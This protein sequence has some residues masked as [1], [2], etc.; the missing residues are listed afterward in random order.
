MFQA[1]FKKAQTTVDN[2]VSEIASKSIVAI[3]F[4]LAIGF[5][6]AAVTV[7]LH[8]LYD[9]ETANTILAIAFAVIGTMV[10]TVEAVRQRRRRAAVAMA[11]GSEQPQV[12][13]EPDPPSS[14][15]GMDKEMMLAAISTAAPVALP[16]V[17]RSVVKNL[18]LVAALAAAGFVLTRSPIPGDQAIQPAE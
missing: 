6:I 8:K 7:R 17:M 15:T 2:A 5:A 14:M 4:L 18:P 10:A 13:V 11:A 1:L 12:A 3:P 9:A 16:Y